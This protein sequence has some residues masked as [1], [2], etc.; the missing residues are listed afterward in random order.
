MRMSGLLYCTI[1][2]TLCNDCIDSVDCVCFA[3]KSVDLCEF[4]WIA[5]AYQ[6]L[7]VNPPFQLVNVCRGR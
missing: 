1:R 2:V 6:C 4:G 7:C 3:A 5:T